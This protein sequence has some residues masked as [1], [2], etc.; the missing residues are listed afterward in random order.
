MRA[1]P[2]TDC[3]VRRRR[4]GVRF[5]IALLA[6]LWGHM[7][8]AQARSSAMLGSR[9]LLVEKDNRTA[10]FLPETHIGTPLQDDEY[11]RTVVRPAF[12]AS[13]ELLAERS[14]APWWDRTFDSAACS[15]EGA[16]EAALDEALAATVSMHA[17]APSPLLRAVT[18][19]KD[20]STLGRF[21]R[22]DRPFFDV[23]M[24]G[25]GQVQLPA[26]TGNHSILMRNAQSGVLLAGSPR[27]VASVENKSTMLD[28]YCSLR[29]AQRAAHIAA[30]IAQSD[31][32]SDATKAKASDASL[33]AM[34][35]RSI[36]A[37]YGQVLSCMR[38][39][40]HR[41]TA[42]PDCGAR[43]ANPRTEPE[44]T[45]N[46]FMLVARSRTWIAKLAT[47]MQRERL[48]FY[49]LGAAHFT[50]GPAGPGLVTILRASGYKVTLLDDRHALMAVLKRLPQ[51]APPSPITL[52]TMHTLAGG[53]HHD[54]FV[55]GC[56]WH[57]ETVSF[58]I[59][60]PRSPDRQEIWS[61]CFQHDTQL[62][63]Q[64]WCTSGRRTAAAE[65]DA[66]LAADKTAQPPS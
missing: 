1:Y 57:D 30:T 14:V 9:L 10:L 20:I 60:N 3:C 12:I 4:M 54:G 47:V 31:G 56:D 53:C 25:I 16:E 22:F 32:P 8:C 33:K 64:K 11:F 29:P 19:P 41:S 66:E 39:D 21:I 62:G 35:Y 49:A 37:E 38:A 40:M 58:I 48:P 43:E 44:L 59:L 34:S 27:R 2:Y 45:I 6:T 65:P 17:V 52:P 13:S 26:G 23:H 28:A 7:V 55:Y 61:A 15:D 5:A 46:R 51:S 18:S 24:R 42:A 50:D 63:P 36:D